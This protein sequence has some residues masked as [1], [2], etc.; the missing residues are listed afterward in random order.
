MKNIFMRFIFGLGS[1]III[2]FTSI[3]IVLVLVLRFFSYKHKSAGT[4]NDIF[5]DSRK[6][7]IPG[8]VKQENSF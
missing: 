4:E 3:L 7:P 6:R 5:L 2:F 1:L 8:G